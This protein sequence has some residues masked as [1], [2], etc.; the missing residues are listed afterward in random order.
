MKKLLLPFFILVFASLLVAC[1]NNAHEDHQQ[2]EEIEEVD[3]H[4]HSEH[5]HHREISFVNREAVEQEA[6]QPPSNMNDQAGNGLLVSSTKNT[7]RLAENDP[8]TMSVI[9]SQTVWPATHEQNQPG[10]VILAPLQEWRYSLA[11]LTLVHHPNDGPLL[12]FDESISE[13]VLQELNRLQP[14]GNVNGTEVIVIGDID[15][16]ELDKLKEYETEQVSAAHPAE[17]ASVIDEYFASIIG[18]Y[19]NEVIIGS[20]EEEAKPYSV[21]VGNWIAHMNESI[22]YVD[23]QGIPEETKAAL[24]KRNSNAMMYVVGPESIIGPEVLSELESFGTVIRIDGE[25]PVDQAIAFAT[26]KNNNTNFGWGITKPGHGFVFAPL[27]LPE[28][29]IAA[30]PFAHLGKHT[31]M[32]WI[33]EGDKVTTSIYHYL[34]TV[35]PAFVTDPTEGPYNHGYLLGDMSVLSFTTQGIIDE[36]LE[37]V[38]ASGEDAHAHH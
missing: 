33:E 9:V 29:A 17:F 28:L 18:S 27:D 25:N 35:K 37:I 5:E 24:E 6:Q 7:T 23:S 21:P 1:T 34:A 3:E 15:A 16:S 36:K 11:A 31:P 10:T 14:K 38:P 13:E 32:L 4:D 12:Y 26:Y 20:L 8:I 22:L 2:N 30:A 19:T